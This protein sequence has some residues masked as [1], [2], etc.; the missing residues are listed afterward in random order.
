MSI[1]KNALIFS[2][3]TK[4]NNLLKLK[5]NCL[6]NY[7]LEVYNIWEFTV[8]FRCKNICNVFNYNLVIILSKKYDFILLKPVVFE[9]LLSP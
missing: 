6:G 8:N 1:G 2:S 3:K 4:K 9:N 5:G 7:Y